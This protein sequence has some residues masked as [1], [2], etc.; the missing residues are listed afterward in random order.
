MAKNSTLTL[1]ALAAVGVATGGLALPALAGAGAAAAA[2]TA[3]AAAATAGTAAVAGTAAAASTFSVSGAL[4]GAST[5]L[6]AGT[7]WLQGQAASTA[8]KI[9]ASQKGLDLAGEAAQFAIQ[10]EDRQLK[11]TSM[12]STQAAIFGSSSISASGIGD[13]IAR[14]TIGTINRETD[15]KTTLTNINQSQIRSGITQ[16]LNAA[17]AASQAGLLKATSS[18][19]NFAG[20]SYDRKR[21]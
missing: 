19:L 20:Q 14:D 2:G 4:L 13:V 21:T 3:G 18:L 6:S 17:S 8:N 9:M 12:L 11:L 15:L 10:E 1:L 5:F 16:D 7:A